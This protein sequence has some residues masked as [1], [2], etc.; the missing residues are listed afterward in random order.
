MVTSQNLL[1]EATLEVRL[2]YQVEPHIQRLR[3][4]AFQVDE[5]ASAKALIGTDLTVHSQHR[6]KVVA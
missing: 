3:E 2:E 5:T 1:E 6:K 4:G